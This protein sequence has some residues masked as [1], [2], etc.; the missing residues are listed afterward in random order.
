MKNRQTTARRSE[1][2]AIVGDIVE[3]LQIL[4]ELDKRPCLVVNVSGLARIPKF[5][6]EEINETALC[7]KMVRMET[8]ITSMNAMFL[9]HI[10]DADAEMKRIN[11]SVEQQSVEI[12]KLKDMKIPSDNKSQR[13][14]NGTHND[15][16]I[17]ESNTASETVKKTPGLSEIVSSRDTNKSVME[18]EDIPEILEMTATISNPIS[19]K[20]TAQSYSDTVRA[21]DIFQQV[22]RKY[23]CGYT[24]NQLKIH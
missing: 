22:K 13:D 7:E 8:K 20:Q 14:V 21:D 6:I 18:A 10:V 3:W 12:V 1:Q 4:T 2:Q 11:D 17:S 19:A 23:Q 24:G 5:Q 15:M 16:V 9:Q